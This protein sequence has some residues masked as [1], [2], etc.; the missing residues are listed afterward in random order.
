ML[1]VELREGH[2]S[3]RFDAPAVHPGHP[4]R[5]GEPQVIGNVAP[6]QSYD[7]ETGLGHRQHVGPDLDRP[8]EPGPAVV[9]AIKRRGVGIRSVVVDHI[10]PRTHDEAHVVAPVPRSVSKHQGH[11]VEKPAPAGGN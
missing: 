9:R 8:H 11:T 7:N 5:Y 3:Q 4:E 1:V 2:P 6:A 10:A